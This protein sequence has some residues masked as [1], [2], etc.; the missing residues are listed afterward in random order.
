MVNVANQLNIDADDVNDA[1]IA[2][3]GTSVSKGEMIDRN[4]RVVWII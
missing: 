1:M 4:E 2:K 3:E